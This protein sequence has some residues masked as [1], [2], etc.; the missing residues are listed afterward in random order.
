MK[1]LLLAGLLVAACTGKL[2]SV[3]SLI[4]V[5]PTQLVFAQATVGAVQELPVQIT[6]S[7]TAELGIQGVKV[8]ADPNQE[9][10]VANVLSAA[11]DGSAR[12]GGMVLDPGECAQ[13]AVRWKP[14]AA[15]D[16]IGSIEVDSDDRRFPV[17]TLPVSGSATGPELQICAL[18]ADGSQ[19]NAKCTGRTTTLTSIPEV[20][21]DPGAVGTKST[22]LVRVLNHGSAAL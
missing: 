14:G 11:C 1:R 18:R 9:L 7:G 16:A 20:D 21:F 4:S 13:F 6:N 22:R 17:I 2:R 15:H 8:S 12:S 10:A 3:D 5:N 19:D